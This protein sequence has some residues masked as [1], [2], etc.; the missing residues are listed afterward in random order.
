M[1]HGQP[2]LCIK[3][4]DIALYKTFVLCCVLWLCGAE[5]LVREQ[6]G[7]LFVLAGEEYHSS[8]R[9]AFFWLEGDAYV[10]VARDISLPS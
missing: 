2:K 7:V 9:R 5:Y 1:L 3:G 4:A 8:W 6:R 10:L